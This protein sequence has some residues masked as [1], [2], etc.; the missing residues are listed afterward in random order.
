MYLNTLTAYC[1]T[2]L[3]LSRYTQSV[4]SAPSEALDAVRVWR[5]YYLK[6]LAV[7]TDCAHFYV[8]GYIFFALYIV[9]SGLGLKELGGGTFIFNLDNT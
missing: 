9:P 3:E 5:Y 2:A 6:L 7:C 8:Q 1:I 4:L